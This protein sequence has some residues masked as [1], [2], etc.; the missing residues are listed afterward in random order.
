M[1]EMLRLIFVLTVTAALTGA[2]LAL[3]NKLTE[4][5]IAAARR[6]ELLKTLNTVLP[7]HDNAPDR[8]T[9]AIQHDGREWTFYPARHDGVY[10]GTAFTAQAEGYGGSITVMVGLD[11]D[12]R[13]H[14]I[15]I[16]SQLETPGLGANIEQ[17]R[18]LNQFA[19]RDATQPPSVRQDNGDIQAVTAATISS[20]A[21]TDAVAKG[22]QAYLA[23][24]AQVTGT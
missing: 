24:R 8:E 12:D 19:G 4:A 10:A 1:K 9:I 5:P 3:A 14:A 21:V 23:N 16:L 2:L 18:F 11:A 7:E 22:L 6:G 13:V 17:P 15:R 20:R